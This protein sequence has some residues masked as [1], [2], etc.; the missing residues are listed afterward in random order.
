MQKA[1]NTTTR[2]QKLILAPELS[3]AIASST[4]GSET[5]SHSFSNELHSGEN[6]TQ[7]FDKLEK[8]H[9]IYDSDGST[10]ST[11]VSMEDPSQQQQLSHL[12]LQT[13][14]GNTL[15]Q[16]PPA[17]DPSEEE[18]ICTALE[19]AP[20][21]HARL[22][23]VFDK[24]GR[25][26][27][28]WK[29]LRP[30][31]VTAKEQRRRQITAKK[32]KV[33]PV[34]EAPLGVSK[35]FN[36]PPAAQMTKA[37]DAQMTPVEGSIPSPSG[38]PNVRPTHSPSHLDVLV[39]PTRCVAPPE[40]SSISPSQVNKNLPAAGTFSSL[41][42]KKNAELK[43]YSY[44]RNQNIPGYLT[45][46][47][48][49]A[50]YGHSARSLRSGL[51]SKPDQPSQPFPTINIIHSAQEHLA[52]PAGLAPL[53]NTS[54]ST[55]ARNNDGITIDPFEARKRISPSPSLS[56]SR[57]VLPSP[58]AREQ[59]TAA[60]LVHDK[61]QQ[62]RSRNSSFCN[63]CRK[64]GCSCE[65]PQESLEE[66][67]C[68]E[69]DC[70]R[71]W[72]GLEDLWNHCGIKLCDA[73]ETKRKFNCWF[74]PQCSNKAR[75]LLD[76]ISTNSSS[77]RHPP[78]DIR[79]RSGRLALNDSAWPEDTDI[80]EPLQ[81]LSGIMQQYTG[82]KT[83]ARNHLSLINPQTRILDIPCIRDETLQPAE[84]V[85]HAIN[86]L[87]KILDVPRG[88][89]IRQKITGTKLQDTPCSIWI[90]GI[91]SF[92]ITN[93]VF[94][95]G[96]PFE[97]VTLWRKILAKS[98]CSHDQAENLI[99]D[100]RIQVMKAYEV[101]SKAPEIPPEFQDRQS[102]RVQDFIEHL[103]LTMLP[104]VGGDNDVQARHKRMANIASE[105]NLKVF[106]YR[107]TFEAV[108]PQMH[109]LF[110]PECHA[111]ENP[112]PGYPDLVG[113]CII[114]TT[115]M[116]VRFKHPEKGW[117]TCS[118]ARVELWPPEDALKGSPQSRFPFP[119][120]PSGGS[121]NQMIRTVPKKRPV[122]DMD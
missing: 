54:S 77:S 59:A 106:A 20:E 99:H 27:S 78:I 114:V 72:W 51:P 62:Q 121:S 71:K 84:T 64:N 32:Q 55:S 39:D 8:C 14:Q 30:R 37:I 122:D 101:S 89:L 75:V 13:N 103:N 68:S 9:A 87:R 119:G 79:E 57:L 116:G 95:S 70:Y 85:Q 93:F 34:L 1:T 100:Y 115:V 46:A 109:A 94:H 43:T 22:S 2:A 98:V 81:A 63:T 21:R 82:T 18:V 90:R 17:D 73:Q 28:R 74:C 108:N 11:N 52:L 10:L 36:T 48:N 5:A 16:L 96:S 3:C 60:R 104:L 56:E 7:A 19:P 24:Q 88:V 31:I 15:S 25:L 42:R 69:R 76:A 107:G 91:L 6:I 12:P 97:D 61:I 33:Q 35:D 26:N 113:R 44:K 45:P 118:Q 65:P 38:D 67:L 4:L 47:Q 105:L 29:R 58:S 80:R 49:H 53:S 117:R 50:E 120:A 110:D 112:E 66:I 86:A 40:N 23:Q 111:E 83:M 41:N 102:R 92:L